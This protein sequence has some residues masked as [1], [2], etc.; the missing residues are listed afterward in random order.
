MSRR[1]GPGHF[2]EDPYAQIVSPHGIPVDDLVS[3]LQKA[4]RRSEVDNAVLA[5]YE[6]C[7]TSPDVAEHLWR[8]LRLIAVEDVGTGLPLAPVLIETLH[9]NFEARPGGDW[10]MACHAVRLLATAPKDRTASEHADWVA[11]MVE[12]GDALVEVPDH[13][14]C[15]HTKAGQELGR[16]LTQWWE[17]GARVHDELPGAEH[18]FRD[19]LIRL[20]R[21]DETENGTEPPPSRWTR[22]D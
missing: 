12:R 21:E 19:E 2:T 22:T 9:R 16:G 6:M 13:A 17:N 1:H 15:V 11:T 20:H 10:M 8:R 18:R 14:H 4:I 3:V 7:T 5:A